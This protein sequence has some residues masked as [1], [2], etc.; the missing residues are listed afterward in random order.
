MPFA[1]SSPSPGMRC[2]SWGVRL[3]TCQIDTAGL[4]MWVRTTGGIRLRWK[5]WAVICL[6]LPKI[7]A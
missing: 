4:E 1:A 5:R 7:S 3:G 6:D 2:V